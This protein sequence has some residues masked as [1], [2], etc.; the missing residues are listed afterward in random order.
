MKTRERDASLIGPAIALDV[1][2]AAALLSIGT[3]HLYEQIRQ[4]KVPIVRI[5]G[6]TVIRRASLERWL[7]EHE[8]T[9]IGG[10]PVIQIGTI[11][12]TRRQGA[13][14]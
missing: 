6:R 7:E 3:A 2:S 12:P 9:E 8:Q 1:A 13:R 4:G 5:G 14:Q 11:E 10:Q